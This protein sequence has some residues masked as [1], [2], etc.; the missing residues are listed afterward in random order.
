MLNN[1]PIVRT[2]AEDIEGTEDIKGFRDYISENWKEKTV[3]TGYPDLDDAIGGGLYPRL[4]VLGGATSTGKTTFAV[5]L[6]Y[7]IAQSGRAVLFFCMEMT[8]HEMTARCLSRIT[9]TLDRDHALTENEILYR[10]ADLPKG[11][12]DLLETAIA[13]FQTEAGKRLYFVEGRRCM[14]G[15]R[16]DPETVQSVIAEVMAAQKPEPGKEYF[17]PVIILD[18]L[19]LLRPDPG[20]ESKTEKELID[21]HLEEIMKIGKDA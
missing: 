19:Q 10:A 18:Y 17:S 7:N 2:A 5:N 8:R 1:L 12:R 11:K 13:K 3:R 15:D 6:A 4:Y 14:N 21:K 9:F 16:D 20:T